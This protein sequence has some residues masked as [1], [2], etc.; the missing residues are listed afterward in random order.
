MKKFMCIFLLLTVIILFS[1]CN[2]SVSTEEIYNENT[3]NLEQIVTFLSN[4]ENVREITKDSPG[5]FYDYPYTYYDGLF[6]VTLTQSNIERNDETEEIN[7][8]I[9]DN[10]VCV[11]YDIDEDIVVFQTIGEFGYGEYIVYTK[12]GEPYSDETFSI[13][14]WLDTNWYLAA[15]N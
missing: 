1:G 11:F 8:T 3:D 10:F 4:N 2:K 5:L 13:S 12:T 6:Y 7:Q 15:T 14:K 9:K